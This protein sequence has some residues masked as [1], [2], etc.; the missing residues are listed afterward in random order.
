MPG[1]SS[2]LFTM[3]RQH[4]CLQGPDTQD[5]DAKGDAVPAEGREGVLLDV[6]H[7][8]ADGQNGDD[9]CHD[10][11]DQQRAGLANRKDAAARQELDELEARRTRHDRGS[12]RRAG[13][14]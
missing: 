5:D 7:Q 2:F 3:L 13:R 8:E 12:C 14:R 6:V 11:A 4:E 10:A 1:D 9:K